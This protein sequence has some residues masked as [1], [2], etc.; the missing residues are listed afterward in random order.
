MAGYGW[1]DAIHPEDREQ[2]CEAWR[3]AVLHQGICETDY[4]I[5]CAD[6]IHRRFNPRAIKASMV[7]AGVP[8]R[9]MS[10]RRP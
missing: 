8:D 10:I 4:R 9:A 2:T 5:R 3:T 1:L 6:G 7:S